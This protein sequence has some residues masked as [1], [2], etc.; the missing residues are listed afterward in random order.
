MEKECTI[1]YLYLI[2]LFLYFWKDHMAGG[3]IETPN[4]QV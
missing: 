3:Q 1:G 4:I 2:I